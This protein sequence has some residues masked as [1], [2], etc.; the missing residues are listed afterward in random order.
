MQA[1][2]LSIEG[3][4]RKLLIFLLVDAVMATIQGISS[5]SLASAFGKF[6]LGSFG[7]VF[8]AGIWQASKRG[9]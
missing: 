5:G 9:R 6:L 1:S 7:S 8:L 4:G 2:F 3:F